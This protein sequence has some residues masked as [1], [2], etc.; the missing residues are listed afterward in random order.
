[1]PKF[2]SI[3][4]ETKESW[5]KMAKSYTE[6]R[7]SGESMNELIEIPGMQALI[8]DVSGLTVLDAGCGYGHYSIWAKKAGAERVVGVDISEKMITEA[9]SRAADK[10]LD[11]EFQVGDLADLN[12]L[13]SE[14]Y[15]LVMSSIVTS[16]FGDLVMY[17]KEFARVLKK[18]GK[19]VFS[20]VHPMRSAGSSITRRGKKDLVVTNYMPSHQQ[21]IDS[22]W[23]DE[24]GSPV[25]ITYYHYTISDFSKALKE[26][27]FLIEEISEPAPVEKMNEVLKEKY[28]RSS[29]IPVFLLIKAVKI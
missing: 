12:Q 9:K 17:F 4:K 22:Q 27:G 10:K 26:A 25:K 6:Y 28:E 15:D 8:G 14:T 2:K 18:G 7:E 23:N 13:E 5:E 1:M 3:A 19:Y 21:T 16:Y 24:N 11:I 20:E 29:R